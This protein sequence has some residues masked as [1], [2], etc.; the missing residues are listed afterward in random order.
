KEKNTEILF[1]T[2]K[3]CS[4]KEYEKIVYPENKTLI[5]ELIKKKGLYDKFSSINYFKLNPAIIKG[6]VDKD[7]IELTKREKAFRLSFKDI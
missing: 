2:N 6:N 5:L 7:I 1:G 3:K 4:I